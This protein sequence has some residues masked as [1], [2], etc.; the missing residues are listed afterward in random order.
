MVPQISNYHAL[1]FYKKTSEEIEQVLHDRGDA[2]RGGRRSI[3]YELRDS[4][5]LPATKLVTPLTRGDF[6]CHGR[7]KAQYNSLLVYGFV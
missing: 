3:F 5:T 7:Y 6:T 2:K 4:P 1:T